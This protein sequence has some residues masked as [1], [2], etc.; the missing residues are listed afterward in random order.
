MLPNVGFLFA[1]VTFGFGFVVAIPVMTLAFYLLAFIPAY[2]F[3]KTWI[4]RMSWVL[5]L[6]IS[7]QIPQ[8]WSSKTILGHRV[9]SKR[10]QV[11]TDGRTGEILFQTSILEFKT[12][13][14]PTFFLPDLDGLST[15][16][17]SGGFVIGRYKQQQS[18][19]GIPVLLTRLTELGVP[20]GDPKTPLPEPIL[21]NLR[22]TIDSSKAVDR[23]RPLAAE[24]A[25][26]K[27]IEQITGQETISDEDLAYFDGLQ[28]ENLGAV[29]EI[30]RAMLHHPQLRAIYLEEYVKSLEPGPSSLTQVQ[31][32]SLARKLV[33]IRLPEDSARPLAPRVEA[34]IERALSH[35]HTPRTLD[36]VLVSVAFG[37][38]P[39]PYLAQLEFSNVDRR[40]V[41]DSLYFLNRAVCTATKQERSPRLPEIARLLAEL[42]ETHKV[43]GSDLIGILRVLRNNGMEGFVE[44]FWRP[45]CPC[46]MRRM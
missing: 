46:V 39:V 22:A 33:E 42:A 23:Y 10:R 17:N 14:L 35:L 18:L 32:K 30:S 45:I 26:K 2:I 24:S 1:L 36:L 28:R 21:D 8:N 4:K 7:N 37:I 40:D 25:I 13:T 16:R 38:D 27:W 5:L 20:L 3:K 41:N 29:T 6:V 12:P 31:R 11:I 34:V 15:G 44:Q 9:T 19:G 43:E